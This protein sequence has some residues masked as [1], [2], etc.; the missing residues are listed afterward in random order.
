MYIA[1][2]REAKRLDSIAQS[3]IFSTLGETLGG[4]LTLRAFRR[5]QA[6]VLHAHGLMDRANRCWWA[7]MVANRCARSPLGVSDKLVASSAP[8]DSS[9]LS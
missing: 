4:L 1:T 7:M 6:V 2:S 3:P 5:Q 9:R 8:S